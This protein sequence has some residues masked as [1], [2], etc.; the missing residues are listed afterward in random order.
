MQVLI[1][2][3]FGPSGR[4]AAGPV[5]ADTRAAKGCF[6]GYSPPKPETDRLSGFSGLPDQTRKCILRMME[7][8]SHESSF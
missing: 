1:P 6:A 3:Q 4:R 7:E 2:R 5:A 8:D